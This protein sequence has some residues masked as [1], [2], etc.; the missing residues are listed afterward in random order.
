MFFKQI[1]KVAKETATKIEM[2]VTT[3]LALSVGWMYGFWISR[4]VND[5]TIIGKENIPNR[6]KVVLVSTHRNLIDSFYLGSII[7]RP[8]DIFLKYWRIPWNTPEE[9]NFFGNK[10]F[11]WLFSRLKNIPIARPLGKLGTKKMLKQLAEVGQKLAL[12]D[13]VLMFLT[14]TRVDDGQIGEC[15]SGIAE[16]IYDH[17]PVVIPVFLDN[18]QRIMPKDVGFDFFWPLFPFI[19]KLKFKP[20]FELKFNPKFKLS[21]RP[22]FKLKIIIKPRVKGLVVIGKPIVFNGVLDK[23]KNGQTRKEIRQTLEQALRDLQN[24]TLAA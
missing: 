15:K 19:I 17:K 20:K 16:I 3:R 24:K 9:S 13:T 4:V 12:G 1:K 11:Y 22:N 6:R 10:F 7:C 18:V 5:V 2:T 8:R 14:G 23:P 21:F